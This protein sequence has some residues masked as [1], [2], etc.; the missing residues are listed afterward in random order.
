MKSYQCYRNW[1]SWSTLCY[2]RICAS[3]FIHW[4]A[5]D[6]LRVDYNAIIF[7]FTSLFV[8]H[9][10]FYHLCYK[11]V[12]SKS[13]R[14]KKTTKNNVNREVI[15]S[16]FMRIYETI[17]CQ[18]KLFFN[19]FIN[20]LSNISFFFQTSWFSLEIFKSSKIKK[21]SHEFFKSKWSFKTQTNHNF[22]K[23][24]TFFYE[25]C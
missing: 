5:S 17:I 22:E 10:E 8:V 24:Q 21:F 16:E 2:C 1:Y 25:N 4:S 20:L 14:Q 7:I 3:A 11:V 15:L 9:T 18:V 19:Q 13:R 6:K 12:F 23:I